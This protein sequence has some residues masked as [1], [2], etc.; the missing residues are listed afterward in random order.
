MS[1]NHFFEIFLMRN[2]TNKSLQKKR[3]NEKKKKSMEERQKKNF[4]VNPFNCHSTKEEEEFIR[5]QFHDF[6]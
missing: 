1:Q 5:I 3:K 6:N 4:V 2:E